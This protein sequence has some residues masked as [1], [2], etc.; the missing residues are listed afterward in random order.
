VTGFVRALIAE[1]EPQ[2]RRSL[3]EYLREADW[4]ELVGEAGDG[5]EAAALI[6]ELRPA[7]VFLDVRM[8]EL[9]GLD[10]VRRIRHRPEIVF[11]T[12]YDQFAVAA[13]ELGALDYL[14]KPFGRR[15]FAVMLERVRRRLGAASGGA[16]R[17]KDTLGPGPLRRLFARVGDRAVPIAVDTIRHIQARGDYSEVH[18]PAGSFL[19]HV[20]LTE[21]LARL[22]PELFCRVHRS[23]AVNVDAVEYFRDYGDR[24]LLV[25]MRDG[26]EIIA[27]RAAS[28]E[29]RRRV[30]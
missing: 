26:V 2:A 4:V 22:D 12:A 20:S 13:F 9:S 28:Q 18:G 1:D 21:L 30:R 15:R 23:H 25:R 27:S 14:M 8:P 10:V 3:R 11:T 16:E 24:R 29:L 5:L 7:L 17:A 6:D 19:L